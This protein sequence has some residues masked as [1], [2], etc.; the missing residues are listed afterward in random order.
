MVAIPLL[1]I[2]AVLLVVPRGA[3]YTADFSRSQPFSS[4]PTLKTAAAR[5]KAAAP[6][7]TGGSTRERYAI[8]IDAGST[9]SRV[10]IFKFNVGAGGALELQFDKFDQL[11]PGLSS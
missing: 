2:V 8:V 6:P 7:A 4:R 10:H 9:G 3:P 1:L 11:R 5:P